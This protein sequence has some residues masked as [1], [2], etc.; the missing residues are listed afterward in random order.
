MLLFCF[1]VGH[2][3]LMLSPQVFLFTSQNVEGTAADVF[4]YL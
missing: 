2:C 3:Y 1:Q 4:D